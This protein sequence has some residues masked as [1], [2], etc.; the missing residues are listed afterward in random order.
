MTPHKSGALQASIPAIA[1]LVGFFKLG[2]FH[3]GLFVLVL[4]LAAFGYRTGYHRA[5]YG[6]ASTK[7]LL[8][9]EIPGK[10][11]QR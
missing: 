8:F 11:P 9:G 7:S 10:P 4:I 5:K 3:L 1:G 2:Q 6:T